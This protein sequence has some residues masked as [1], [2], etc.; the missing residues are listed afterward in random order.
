LVVLSR[1]IA[2]SPPF[3]IVI[4]RGWIIDGTG[5]PWYSADIGIRGGRIAAIGNL[6]AARR[7]RSID[8]HGQVVAP[9]FIDMLGQS[10]LTILV[11]PRLPSKIYQGITTEITGEGESVAPMNDAI[12][13][14]GKR[15]LDLLGIQADW[16]TFREYFARL[17]KQG[18]GIN[19]A[20][21]V[22]ATTVRR[23]ALGDDDVQPT[24][25][26]LDQMKQL[27]RQAMLDGAV[28]V[29]TSLEYPP[30]PYAKTEE[31]IALASEASRFG[32]IY[33]THMRSESTAILQS[34]D[35]VIRIARE[36]QIP[37]EIWHF[38][39]AGKPS[40]GH[41]P[42]AIAKIEAARARGV[43][44]AADTYAYTAWGNG[45][46]AFIPPWA[47]D[48][49]TS[50]LLERLKDPAARERIRKDMLT[51]SDEWENEWQQIP[52]PESIL[53]GQVQ[54]PKLLSLQGK[55]IAEVAK[56][57]NK[58]PMDTIF[59][60]LI[61]DDAFTGV[62]VSGMAEPD[63]ALA[64]QQPWVSIDNDSSGVSPEGILGREHSHP[65][66]Y[67]TFPRILRKYVREEHKLTLED[68]IRKFSALPAQRLRLEGRGLLR[69]DM[70]ADVTIFDPATI[71]DVATFENPNQLSQGIDYVLVN[72][73]PVIDQGKMT[74]ARPG[75]VLRGP[76]YAP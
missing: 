44:M 48:G 52:G 37:I 18:I 16:Q 70:W 39:V 76:G 49:G 28:G 5:S 40:W 51:P 41:M 32:G 36:A 47:H 3:D 35:E 63:V 68:A 4:T 55:T 50:K 8:A 74:G 59:D 71:R 45:L 15:Q 29:S 42:E 66:A 19:V 67:G 10:E 22:G 57:W 24:P 34:L 7:T 56:L 25:E 69:V 64:L 17:E 43:D 27:V 62:A 2:Q 23:M 21:Y 31:L 9:G 20:D 11:D 75:K 1:S 30:A 53:I 73:V 38:K 65:R 12:R 46:S 14:S 58:N 61:Q 13:R 54:N 60:L 26:Q 6:T 72:G 33:A